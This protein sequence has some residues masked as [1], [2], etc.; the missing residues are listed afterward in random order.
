MIGYLVV[1]CFSVLQAHSVASARETRAQRL[2]TLR[3]RA[4]ALHLSIDP[5]G[6]HFHTAI[7]MTAGGIEP[8]TDPIQGQ[9][10]PRQQ[11]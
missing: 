11:P 3:L 2:P 4:S 7:D 5:N 1:A 8:P 10:A 9:C 6:S